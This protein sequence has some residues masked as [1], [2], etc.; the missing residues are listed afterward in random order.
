M[1]AKVR[2]NAQSE[3][4]ADVYSVA[5][6]VLQD[7]GCLVCNQLISSSRLPIESLT[8]VERREI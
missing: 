3:D 1:G 7:S 4:V 2:G 6:L 8:D 5:R